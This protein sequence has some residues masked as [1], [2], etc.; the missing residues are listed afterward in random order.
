MKI[1]GIEG[2][3]PDEAPAAWGAAVVDLGGRLMNGVSG[4]MSPKPVTSREIF[5]RFDAIIDLPDAAPSVSVYVLALR[6]TMPEAE[7]LLAESG[8]AGTRLHPFATPSCRG[9]VVIG[10]AAMDDLRKRLTGSI[11]QRLQTHTSDSTERSLLLRA[12][13]CIS[14]L[15]RKLRAIAA[16]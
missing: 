7:N 5:T 1:I 10:E 2:P 6:Q 16:R 9:F 8:R 13:L 15:D 4:E 14:P 3:W 12:G 11:L